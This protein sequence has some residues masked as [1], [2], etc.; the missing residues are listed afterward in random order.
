MPLLLATLPGFIKFFVQGGF[1]MFA[2]LILSVFSLAVILQRA[3]VI[4]MDRALPMEV[5]RALQAFKGGS[6]ETLERVLR[7]EPSPL[8]RVLDNV[9]QHRNWP[10][11]EILDAVQT[12]ARHEIS[13]LESGLVFLEITTGISPL[14]GLL[15]TL[16]GL[17]GIFANIGG[18]PQMVANGISE[19]LNC[20]I[21]GLGVAV[22]NLVA[23]NYFTR[24]V[25]VV[26]IELESLTTDLMTKLSLSK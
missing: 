2:L 1:F 7:Q 9:L 16:S 25:E 24:R 23:Y 22:P 15:G 26:S 19:A 4:K 13:R 20:T 11:T 18:D 3:R 14:L 17:V 12:R 10:R 6:T 21:V 5:I 8:S